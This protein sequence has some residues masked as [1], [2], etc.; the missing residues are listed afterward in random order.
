[1]SPAPDAHVV[2]LY[3]D[4]RSLVEAVTAST[5]CALLHGE[6]A[7]VLATPDHRAELAEALTRGGLAVGR[8]RLSGQYAELDAESVLAWASGRD[9]ELDATLLV[10]A[11][12]D[13][14]GRQTR[15]WRRVCVYSD[16]V[17]CLWGRGDVLGTLRLEGAWN[18]LV[19]T[20]PVRLHCGY[21]SAGFAD[22]GSADQA[23]QVLTAHSD[24]RST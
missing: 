7:L 17:S 6:A 20:R 23:L 14:L 12:D 21:D 22:S 8:L 13:Q 5:G 16:L 19:R 1:M 24:V 11:L 15:R 18:E 3:D 9:G 10:E 4:R 2:Q